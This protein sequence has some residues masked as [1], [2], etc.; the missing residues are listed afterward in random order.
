MY[1]GIDI[2]YWLECHWDYDEN[3]VK[4]Y[5]M[6]ETIFNNQDCTDVNESNLFE[7]GC[8]YKDLYIEFTGCWGDK[9]TKIDYFNHTVNITTSSTSNENN[10]N[11]NI[12]HHYNCG[13]YS[14]F[15][16]IGVVIIV[17]GFILYTCFYCINYEK[18]SKPKTKTN[19]LENVA[20]NSKSES[21]SDSGSSIKKEGIMVTTMDGDNNETIMV[22]YPKKK[23]N[24][25]N[26]QES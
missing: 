17:F 5:I 7:G 1:T 14:I 20:E 19:T 24:K 23:Y 15:I 11:N 16:L 13:G 4:R 9:V 8:E 12:Y 22:S 18:E 21:D 26:E 25:I 6:N 10:D 3:G 2:G